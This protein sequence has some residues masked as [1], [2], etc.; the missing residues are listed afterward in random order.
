MRLGPQGLRTEA[1]FFQNPIIKGHVLDRSHIAIGLGPQIYYLL[2]NQDSQSGTT[3][4]SP[5]CYCPHL[6]HCPQF[7]LL[8]LLLEKAKELWDPHGEP[9]G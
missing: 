1:D 9:Y 3:D 8:Q 7:Q 6:S 2:G 5:P 4:L